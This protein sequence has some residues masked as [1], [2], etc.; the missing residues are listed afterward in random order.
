MP[1]KQVNG[2]NSSYDECGSGEPVLLV[3]GTGGRG[4]EWTAHQVPGLREVG[5]RVVPMDNRGVPPSDVGPV[6]FTINDMVADTVGLIEVLRMTPCRIVGYSLGGII[7]QEAVL[8]YPSIMKQAVLIATRGRTD[9]MRAALS[10]SWDELDHSGVKLP[11][12]Y[13]AV[14]RAMQYLP[15]RSLDDEQRARDWLDVF[16]MSPEDALIKQS[17]H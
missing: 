16:E 4:R 5:Y 6:G 7:V 15:P 10:E 9:A 12:K 17:Q 11:P 8:A 2:I 1:I 13:A 14:A 3:N